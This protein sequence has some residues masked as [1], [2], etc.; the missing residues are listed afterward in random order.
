M[1]NRTK[2]MLSLRLLNVRTT[3]EGIKLR[4]AKIEL[5]VASLLPQELYAFA[6]R[7]RIFQK[8]RTNVGAVL[9][10]VPAFVS[11]GS[12]AGP[13]AQTSGST[14]TALDPLLAGKALAE[15]TARGTF[16]VALKQPA[17]TIRQGIAVFWHRPSEFVRG[18]L[19]ADLPAPAIEETPGTPAFEELHK[20][21]GFPRPVNGTLRW[22]VDGAEFFPELDRQISSARATIEAQVYIFDN[23]DVGVRYANALRRQ[24]EQVDVRVLYD[25]FG[26]ATAYLSSPRTPP[27]SDFEP[28]ADM[29]DYLR[30]NSQVE[31]RLSLNPWLAAD[32]TKLLI[33]D[34]RTAILGGMNIGREYYSEWHDLMVKIEGPVVGRLSEIFATA[35]KNSG[36][37]GDLALFAPMPKIKGP[38]SANTDIPIRILRTESAS[39]RHE[40]LDSTLLASARSK[41]RVWIETPYFASDEIVEAVRAA[42]LR[43]VDVRVIFP[44]EGDSRIMD[45]GNLATARVLMEAGAKTHHYPRMT[46][47]KVMVCDDWATMGSANLDTLSMR[48]NRELNI[49][50]SGEAE[51]K[52]LVDRVFL[53]DFARSKRITKRETETPAAALAEI[54]AR[55]AL[56]LDAMSFPECAETIVVT[57][58][59]IALCRMRHVPEVFWTTPCGG[60][61]MLGAGGSV[62]PDHAAVLPHRPASPDSVK[63]REAVRCQGTT[64]D[65]ALRATWSVE[66]QPV[67][68]AADDPLL[69]GARVAETGAESI[70]VFKISYR[71]NP[72]SL[73]HALDEFHQPVRGGFCVEVT[74]E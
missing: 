19:P 18:T 73:V 33:F 41:R 64:G 48:I 70:A 31:A 66:C 47:M 43:G 65:G 30:E 28:P 24:A 67:R 14:G 11:C 50:F 2:A 8:F 46:H 10:A 20:R 71:V 29:A 52:G 3:S 1:V 51:V 25:D 26:T 49:A 56:E 54:V 37:F 13:S 63:F 53:P 35:W 60:I 9:L 45:M 61:V 6:H 59:H 55:P 4:S 40:I 27:P 23:D 58:K 17:T 74:Y 7:M 42:A 5:K 36:P 72:R 68:R 22:L 69:I 62:L 57:L 12:L 15:T 32:H 38:A 39:G 21:K 44:A 34:R 16:V